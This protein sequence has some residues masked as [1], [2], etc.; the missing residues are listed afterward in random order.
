MTG[1]LRPIPEPDTP[2]H[3]DFLIEA[4]VDEVLIYANFGTSEEPINFHI[5]LLR[6]TYLRALERKEDEG[7]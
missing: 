1:E 5:D 7:A 3:F 6:Q 2:E 4:L